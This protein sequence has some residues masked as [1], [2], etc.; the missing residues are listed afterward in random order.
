MSLKGEV[1]FDPAYAIETLFNGTA[2]VTNELSP[3]DRGKIK[4]T[5]NSAGLAILNSIF[6]KG[7]ITDDPTTNST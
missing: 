2:N 7:N 4:W 3:E 1:M 5:N 6:G